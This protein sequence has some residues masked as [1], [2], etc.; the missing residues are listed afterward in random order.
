MVLV[1]TVRAGHY[2][3]VQCKNPEI[4]KKSNENEDWN[5]KENRKVN[6]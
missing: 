4:Q 5:E 1:R 3:I 2:E 6:E